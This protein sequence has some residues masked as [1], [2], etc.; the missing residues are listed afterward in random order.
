MK[1]GRPAMAWNRVA[2][3]EYMSGNDGS[4][5]LANDGAL[6]LAERIWLTI[7][8]GLVVL[9]QP[10]SEPTYRAGDYWLMPARVALGD[11]LWPTDSTGAPKAQPPHGVEHHYAPLAVIDVRPDEVSLRQGVLLRRQFKQLVDL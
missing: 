4:A 11:V 5:E 2:A 9:F 1:G 10:E 7:E 6:R 3:S 8:D